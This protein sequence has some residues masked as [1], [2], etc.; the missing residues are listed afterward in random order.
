[1]INKIKRHLTLHGNLYVYIVSIV[2]SL[3]F[4]TW[5]LFISDI[6]KNFLLFL[7]HFIQHHVEYAYWIAFTAAI[8]EGTIILGVLPGTTYI[9]T[10]G[11]FLARGD[12]DI[13]ILL[14]LVIVGAIIGDLVGYG[15]GHFFSD[16]MKRNY[17]EDYNYKLSIKFIE[18][19]GGKSVFIARFI[20]G[21]KEF[22]PFIAGILK[23]PLKKFMFWN[24][25][26]AIG[27]SIFWLTIGYIGGTYI[28]EVQNIVKVVGGVLM[29]FFLFSAYIYYQR[30]KDKLMEY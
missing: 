23:M 20:S 1:M 15:I 2:I 26:G 5:L 8:V 17:K 10:M 24:F 30:N 11:V 9:I 14:P 27:W 13:E 6:F 29:T 18:K 16:Y 25:L 21:I 7:E 22:V 12:L 28:E 3:S 4:A 19:H